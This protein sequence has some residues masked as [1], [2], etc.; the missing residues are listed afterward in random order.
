MQ[1]AYSFSGASGADAVVLCLA[2]VSNKED[3]YCIS[4]AEYLALCVALHISSRDSARDMQYLSGASGAD[5]VVFG[6]GKKSLLAQRCSIWRY[7]VCIQSLGSKRRRCSSV[8]FG[9]GKKSLL[10]QRCRTTLLEICSMWQ[11]RNTL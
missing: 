5:S 6:S 11:W 10:A 2:V 8:V 9:S 7:A 4:L 1:Y 3:K